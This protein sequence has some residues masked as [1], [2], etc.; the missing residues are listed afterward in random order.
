MRKKEDNLFFEFLQVAI[1]IR[2]S[3]SVAIGDSD[4]LRLFEFCKRQTL[5]GVGFSAVE[6]LHTL[7][8][9]CPVNLRMKWM[10]LVLQ[11]ERRN[12]LLNEQCKKLTEQYEHDGLSTCI[13]KGQ[14]N[15]L[16]YPEELRMRRMSGDIDVWC[17]PPKDG[18]DIAVATGNIDV[19][20]VNYKGVNAVIEYARMQ[21]RLKGIDANPKAC[22]HHIEAPMMD[23]TEVEVH[24]RPAFLRSPLR[25]WRM[26]RWI[27]NHTDECM[28]NKT[29]LGFSMMASSVNV[30]YQMCHLYT[31]VFEGGIGLRQLMDYY[32]ALKIWHNDVMECKDLQSQGMWSEGLGTAVMSATEIMGV[33]RSFGMGKFTAAVMWVLNEVFGGVNENDNENENCPHMTQ[34]DTDWC[35]QADIKGRQQEQLK[36]TFCPQADGRSERE[37][38]RIK[39]ELKEIGPQADED[40]EQQLAAIGQQLKEICPQSDDRSERECPQIYSHIANIKKSSSSS[41]SFREFKKNIFVPWMICEPNEKEGRKLMAE[42]MQGG[43]FGQYDTRDAALKKG[44]MMKHGVWKLKRV[45]RLVSSYPEEALW[46]P[47]FRVYHLVWR[48]ING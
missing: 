47:V 19:K 9:V 12:A 34:M 30:V 32:F 44:G 17:I 23:G 5:T 46:E 37:F 35:P 21:F 18:L 31:H 27:E 13:L 14:G 4:W 22:Y 16:N 7:G 45:M 33:L 36:T 15:C 39:R 10:A 42:I 41:A 43:N 6:K 24:Y 38:T 1:G 28:K 11:I 29:Q 20:Y 3:L 2:K 25:N 8:I 48:G 40:G 26:Q